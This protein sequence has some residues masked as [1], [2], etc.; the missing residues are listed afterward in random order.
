ML[1]SVC[2]PTYS[3]LDYL[4][5]AVDS[6]LA[7]T[8]RDFE[9][10]VALDPK[11]DGPDQAIHLWCTAYAALNPWFRY[12]VN[13]KNVGLAGNWNVLAQMSEGDYAIIIGDDDTL[14][15]TYLENVARNIGRVNPDVVFTDQNFINSSGEILDAFTEEMS[16]TYHRKNL[17]AGVLPD[18]IE[19]VLK[20]TVPMS[21]AIIRRDLLIKYPFDPTLNTPELEVFLKIAAHGGVFEYVDKRV[22]NY[23]VHLESATSG[24]LKLHYLLR[25]LIPIEVPS[26]YEELKYEL[27][28]TKMIPAVNICLREGNKSLGRSLLNSKYYPKGKNHLK[29]IQRTLMICPS[30]IVNRVL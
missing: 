21:S 25:N 19:T 24:G 2:I 16:V 3:R 17:K 8:F 6:V 27:I 18:P 4:K 10:C 13:H 5:L 14:E 26:K 15:P 29:I 1:I 23:R 30:F 20:N 7:Q 28:S 12:L 22:A 9:V 11:P